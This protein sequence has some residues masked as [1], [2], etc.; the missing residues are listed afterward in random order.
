M[1]D[2]LADGNFA[3]HGAFGDDF[4]G[5]RIGGGDGVVG[6]RREA[7]IGIV[8][9]L[10]AAIEFLLDVLDVEFVFLGFLWERLGRPAI[11]AEIWA[12]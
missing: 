2:G 3:G 8:H 1:L 7:G 10:I 6:F 12:S 4:I 11:G 5:D 9:G